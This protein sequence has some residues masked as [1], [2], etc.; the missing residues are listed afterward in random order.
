MSS[1]LYHLF[2]IS[3]DGIPLLTYKSDGLPAIPFPVIGAINGVHMY[4]NSNGVELVSTD[5]GNAKIIWKEYYS[6]KLILTLFSKNFL[7]HSKLLDD[8]FYAFVITIGLNSLS[9]ILSIEKLKKKL[10][11]CLPLVSLLM[12]KQGTI[13]NLRYMV[14][15]CLV[16]QKTVLQN[17]LN[18]FI[19]E[20]SCELGCLLLYNKVIVATESF[21]QMD[22]KDIYFITMFQE[23]LCNSL[24]ASD[25]PIFLPVSS[26]DIP[27]RLVTFNLIEHVKI[28]L[29]CGSQPT[30]SE[31]LKNYLH[32]YWMP[33]LSV[34]KDS[35]T[36]YP[37]CFPK[38]IKLD[39]SILSFV[40]LN[41][42]EEMSWCSLFP[43]GSMTG[44]D[45]F[46]LCDVNERQNA[47]IAFYESCLKSLEKEK[48]LKFVIDAKEIY[49]CTEQF[50]CY[51]ILGSTYYLFVLYKK[52]T[53]TFA[54]P[55]VSKNM[56]KRLL[57]EKFI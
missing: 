34:L 44:S 49:E 8:I 10:R 40:L 55:G 26:P 54:L 25:T 3:S 50:K 18:I 15:L 17:Q 14:D 21:W 52:D 30:L 33:L 29:I 32:K 47:L 36:S 46:V 2:C 27:H 39:S 56:L 51:A 37:R 22:K 35:L 42:K 7:H 28:V 45:Q 20:S 41:I 16:S 38:D 53:A 1:V 57:K 9:K 43:H 48:N 19:Q 12:R 6:V 31:L 24:S 4:A 11:T 23:S 13:N 5:A